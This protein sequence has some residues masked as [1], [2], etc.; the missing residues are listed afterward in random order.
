M[1]TSL[2][3]LAITDDRGGT[4]SV[5]VGDYYC[6]ERDLYWVSELYR[7]ERDGVERALIEDCRTGE[8]I[9]MPISELLLL[10]PVRGR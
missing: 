5:A 2:D 6:S 3:H 9:D 8:M 4:S 1:E 7:V 10:R